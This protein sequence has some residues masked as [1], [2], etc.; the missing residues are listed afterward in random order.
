MPSSAELD[1]VLLEAISALGGNATNQQIYVWVVTNLKIPQSQLEIM[2]SGN[3]SELE[4]RLAWARTRASKR[5]SIHRS[6]PSQ[7]RLGSKP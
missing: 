5:G 4:Y 7:W 3:R 6:G 2:R 1:R